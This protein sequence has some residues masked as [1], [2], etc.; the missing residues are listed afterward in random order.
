MCKYVL[1]QTSECATILLYVVIPTI[2]RKGERGIPNGAR[3]RS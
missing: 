3:T 2:H 1:K